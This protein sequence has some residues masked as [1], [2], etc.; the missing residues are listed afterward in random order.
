MSGEEAED[1]ST[2]E[3]LVSMLDEHGAEYEV[4]TH[5]PVRTS[6]EAAQVRGSRLSQGAKAMIFRSK[7]QFAMAIVP[8]DLTIDT[9]LLKKLLGWKSCSMASA[10]EVW[11][12]TKARPG[13]VPPFGR[14][15]FQLQTLCDRQI[16]R[17][18]V[19]EFNAGLR[20]KSVRISRE[21]WMRVEAPR[22]EDYAK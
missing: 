16:E 5:A 1:P 21:E 7:G 8:A 17:E 12:L 9:K 19:L 14:A 22:V 4:L 11:Q 20:G 6:E 2:F 3:R 15:L 13:G 10:E 18:E